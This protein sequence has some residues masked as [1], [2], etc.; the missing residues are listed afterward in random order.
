[1]K[2]PSRW[3]ILVHAIALHGE[4][5]RWATVYTEYKLLM[6]ISK[7]TRYA[8]DSY[9]TRTQL[10]PDTHST[11]TR[12]ALENVEWVRHYLR[13]VPYIYV[14]ASVMVL[15]YNDALASKNLAGTVLVRMYFQNM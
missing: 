5:F 4:S 10:V 13:A 11:R 14:Y 1:M 15:I 7:S 3:T 9:P 6:Q 8:L 12:L 2:K